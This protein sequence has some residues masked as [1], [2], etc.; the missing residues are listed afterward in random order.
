MMSRNFRIAYSFN[1]TWRSHGRLVL[2][3]LFITDAVNLRERNEN[4]DFFVDCLLV[5]FS[6]GVT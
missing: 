2:A 1:K 3:A 4:R 6:T 5:S